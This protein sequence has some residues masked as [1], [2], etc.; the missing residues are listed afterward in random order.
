MPIFP[1][2]HNRIKGFREHYEIPVEVVLNALN[3]PEDEYND[4][5]SGKVLPTVDVLLKLADLYKVTLKEFYGNVPMKT[6]INSGDKTDTAESYDEDFK[7]TDLSPIEKELVLR[8]R[9][10]LN[11]EE[12]FL[13]M[14]SEMKKENN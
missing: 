5:E 14:T 8:Y 6:E 4:Y 11:K 3:M 2:I 9:L 1:S 7:F 10:C 12:L 13:K